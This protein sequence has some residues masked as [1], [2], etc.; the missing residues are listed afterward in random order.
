LLRA[1]QFGEFQRVGGNRAIKVDARIIAATH[2]N[3]EEMIKNSQFRDD[4]YYRLNVVSIQVPALRNRKTDI[5]VLAEHFLQKYRT[6]NQKAVEGLTKEALDQLMKYG[7]PGNVR[8]LENIIERAVVLCRGKVI[9]TSDLPAQIL[10]AETEGLLNPANLEDGYEEKM[11]AFEKE[12]ISRALQ[13]SGGNKS[14]AARLLG[15]SE[16]H[17]RSRLERIK[18]E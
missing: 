5:P 13:E 3:L 18:L 12:M 14:A 11:Q 16:R 17:L 6:E 15:I 10:S 1:I 9:T 7:F 4:L 2:R 8:E